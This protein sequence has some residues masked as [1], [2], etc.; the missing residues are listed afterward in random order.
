M[1][2]TRLKEMTTTASVES[3]DAE[4]HAASLGQSWRRSIDVILLW[5]LRV[6]GMMLMP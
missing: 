3:C 4:R 5:S 2:R 1:K 6:L